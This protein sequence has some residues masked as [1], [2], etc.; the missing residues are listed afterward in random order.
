MRHICAALLLAGT[1]LIPAQ[2]ATAQGFNP[3][4]AVV[5]GA[6]GAGVGSAVSGGNTGATIAGGVIGA[7]A[8]AALTM[9]PRQSGYYWYNNR[10]WARYPNG[11]YHL[12]SRRFCS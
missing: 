5:G 9:E 3:L 7:A 10:C 4:G 11:D 12:V 6:V 8:G 2:H 1:A